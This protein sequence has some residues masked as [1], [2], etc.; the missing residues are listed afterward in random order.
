[1]SSPSAPAGPGV[2]SQVAHLSRRAGFGLPPAALEALAAGGLAAAI[3]HYVDYDR[4]PDL[5]SLAKPR[6][7]DRSGNTDIAPAQLWWLDR[8]IRSPRQLEE[9]MTLFWHNLFAT[10][11]DKVD[12]PTFMWQQNMLFRHRALDDFQH[13]LASVWSDHAM[14]YWLDGSYS[15]KDSPNENFARECMELFSIGVGNYTQ[16]DVRAAARAF[17]GYYIDDSYRRHFDPGAHDD[18]IKTFLGQT[19]RW[20]GKD[21]AR[22][23][24]NQPACGRFL[25]RKLWTFFAYERPEDSVVEEL[26]AV[27]RSNHRSIRAVLRHLFGMPQFYSPLALGGRVKGPIEFAVTAVRELESR[28][29][30]SDINDNLWGMGQSPFYPPNVGGWPS[31]PR[32]INSSTMIARFNWVA[33]LLGQESDPRKQRVDHALLLKR[34]D[35]GHWPGT[36]ERFARYHLAAPATPGTRARVSLAAI[37]RFTGGR[38][39]QGDDAVPTLVSALHLLM[40]SPEY[41]CA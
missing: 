12:R 13:L 40:V 11:E 9:K 27:Y 24:A 15:S 23:L 17:T 36:L 28:M 32:W 19:G 33:Y 31:G 21:I 4:L 30:L 26:A 38:T 18:G 39:T 16:R 8:M 37:G 7:N 22:I 1:M 6:V 35:T 29:K 41:Y 14:L 3:D 10:S 20:D 34:Y 5:L 25:A 2:L